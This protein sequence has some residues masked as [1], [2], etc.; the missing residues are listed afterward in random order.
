MET[1]KKGHR[2][3]QLTAFALMSWSFFMVLYFVIYHDHIVQQPLNKIL[4][5]FETVTN[6]TVGVLI[7]L[8]TLKK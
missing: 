1:V 4:N 3:S 2:A 8:I 7:L 6:Y 5:I